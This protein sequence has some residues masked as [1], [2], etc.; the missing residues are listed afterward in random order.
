M[1]AMLGYYAKNWEAQIGVK[2]L[3]DVTYFTTAQ[4]AGG[5][6]ARPRTFYAKAAWHY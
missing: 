6:V 4:S 3:T 5:Y 1:E 2:N